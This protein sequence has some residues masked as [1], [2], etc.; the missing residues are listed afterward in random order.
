MSGVGGSVDPGDI[1]RCLTEIFARHFERLIAPVA[2]P[3]EVMPIFLDERERFTRL[4]AEAFN[5][6][7]GLIVDSTRWGAGIPVSGDPR[8]D[9]PDLTAAVEAVLIAYNAI[10]PGASLRLEISAGVVSVQGAVAYD[11][12]NTAQKAIR[13]LLAGLFDEG[14]RSTSLA[15]VIW[16]DDSIDERLSVLT[17]QLLI[18]LADLLKLDVRTTLV[19]IAGDGAVNPTV[20]CMG[21]TSVRYR[22]SDAGLARRQRWDASRYA[23]LELAP[24]TRS[25][26]P[27]L[28]LFLGAGTSVV[29]GLPTGNLL[30]DRALA[31]LVDIPKVDRH[32]YGA[33]S[34]ELFRK[35]EVSGGLRAGEKEN[36]AGL[37]AERLTL[38]RVLLVEQSQESQLDCT[39]LRAF[40]AEHTAIVGALS[41]AAA[42][43]AFADDPLV[44][45]LSLQQRI[46]IV[47]VNFDRILETKAPGL[48]E[49]FVTEEELGRVGAY[50]S[51]YAQHGGPVPVIKLHGDINDAN[52]LVVNVADTSAGLSAVRLK[53]LHAVIDA[54]GG[55]PVRHWWYVGYSMR[56]LDLEAPWS[57]PAFADQMAEHWVAPFIDPAVERFLTRWRV[58]RWQQRG[59]PHTV[60]NRVVTLTAA[61]FFEILYKEVASRWVPIV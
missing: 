15:C 28:V 49:P 5:T 58:E 60:A 41:H 4:I 18:K 52:S 54:I 14:L 22:I 61:D 30:R 8:V 35:L 56:D 27:L 50:L 37:F 53:A 45:L 3:A 36:G 9:L 33:A 31:R 39:T 38:E 25:E 43:G 6:A 11:T 2:Q 16:S 23:V 59:L 26:T 46:V 17:W 19:L 47:T 32:N 12:A 55:Q 20:H 48:T 42:L 34:D 40:R 51:H 24:L 1:L 10:D 13:E 44:G 7:D 57:N 29:E 21:R